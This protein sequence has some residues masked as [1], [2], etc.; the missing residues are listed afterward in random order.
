MKLTFYVTLDKFLAFFGLQF[1]SGKWRG[2]TGWPTM[3]WVT[4]MVPAMS[5]PSVE[6]ER[7]LTCREL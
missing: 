7:R 6:W 5:L 4:E 1:S 2:W 3:G